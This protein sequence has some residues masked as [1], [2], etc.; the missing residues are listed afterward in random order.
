MEG[1]ALDEKVQIQRLWAACEEPHQRALH[2]GGAGRVTSPA[3][4]LGLIKSLAVKGR[5]NLIN[6]IGMQ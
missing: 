4:L 2:N 6:I 5:K 1:T 3:E